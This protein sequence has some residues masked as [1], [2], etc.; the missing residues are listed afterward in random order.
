[1]MVFALASVVSAHS[2]CEDGRCKI[3]VPEDE[4]S[5]IQA[6]M[7]H[8]LGEEVEGELRQQLV[9]AMTPEMQKVEERRMQEHEKKQA[10]R[11]AQDPETKPKK[12][13]V[14]TKDCSKRT[15]ITHDGYESKCFQD[16][17]R[18]AASKCSPNLI[19]AI[20]MAGECKDTRPDDFWNNFGKQ[21]VGKAGD[22]LIDAL[23]VTR[24]KKG[25]M[26]C[27]GVDPQM[28]GRMSI[29][30]CCDGCELTDGSEPST[31]ECKKA[32][33]PDARKGLSSSVDGAFGGCT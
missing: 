28:C 18:C 20:K 2:S 31:A 29:V 26:H 30:G 9:P 7:A 11:R 25:Y 24:P 27:P 8:R 19:K 32:G 5:L 10:E 17:G 23:G 22:A 12:V 13:I 4:V 1:M 6:K 21:F 14:S 15:F 16:G 33:T 3:E